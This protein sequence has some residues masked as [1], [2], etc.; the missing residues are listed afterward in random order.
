ME[1]RQQDDTK[2]KRLSIQRMTC[3]EASGLIC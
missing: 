2:Y 1:E 3:K